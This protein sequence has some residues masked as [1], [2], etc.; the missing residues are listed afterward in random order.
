MT[1]VEVG[2]LALNV[3]LAGAG[4]P[5]V[6]LHGFTGAAAGWAPIV[7]L[8]AAEFTTLAIDIVGHGRSDAPPQVDRYAMARCVDDLV[9]A[10]RSLGHERATWLG[11]SMGGRTAL[12]L[13]VLRPEAVSAL[14]LEGTTPGLTGKARIDRMVSDEGLA[15]RIESEGV[16]AF[17]DYWEAVPLF[18]TQRALPDAVRVAI[19]EGR[20]R[21]SATGLANS[22]R[23]MGAGAQEPIHDRL[24]EVRVPA[25]LVAGALDEKFAAIAREMAQALPDARVELIEDAG[26]AAHIERPQAFGEAVLDF[27]RRVHASEDGGA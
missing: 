19:R 6:L 26:H 9:A 21:N 16:P 4:P 23:G 27:L 20:L 7:E 18:A 24:R 13:A 11:Y 8:L 5:V 1:V 25:L 17:V 12:Q 3:E 15:G 2:G 10:L 14:V 22:L